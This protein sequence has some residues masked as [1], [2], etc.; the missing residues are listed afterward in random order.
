MWEKSRLRESS[1]QGKYDPE[2][3]LSVIRNLS[4]SYC[5]SDPTNPIK[6][7]PEFIVSGEHVSG[8]QP[9]LC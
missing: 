4:Q 5:R 7:I 2:A 3:F 8:Y 9:K 1:D 6:K